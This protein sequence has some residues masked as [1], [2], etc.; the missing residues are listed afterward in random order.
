MCILHWNYLYFHLVLFPPL[1][2]LLSH[3]NIWEAVV[4]LSRLQIIRFNNVFH[5]LQI[6][7]KLFS[8]IYWVCS[9]P[10]LFP[11]CSWFEWWDPAFTNFSTFPSHSNQIHTQN[12]QLNMH[13]EVSFTLIIAIPTF[14]HFQIETLQKRKKLKNVMHLSLTRYVRRQIFGREVKI[15]GASF[16]I[17]LSRSYNSLHLFAL[18]QPRCDQC[19]S[20]QDSDFWC[21]QCRPPFIPLRLFA[22][23]QRHR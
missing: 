20:G 22:I 9:L 23:S 3:S 1:M 11:S 17:L 13:V 14:P 19:S 15:I 5:T 12:S 8:N 10:S 4:R 2:M 18:T 6:L 7:K 16:Y 21:L